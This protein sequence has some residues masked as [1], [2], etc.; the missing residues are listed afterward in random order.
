LLLKIALK[1]YK[2]IWEINKEF[3]LYIFI[4]GQ[5]FFCYGFD[6]TIEDTPVKWDS[7]TTEINNLFHVPMPH[8]YQ[9]LFGKI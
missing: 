4:Y 6:S 7:R 1:G 9:N 8:F 5:N 2:L 3:K